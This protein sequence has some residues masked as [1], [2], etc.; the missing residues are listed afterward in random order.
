[1]RLFTRKQKAIY[2]FLSLVG[3]CIV[4]SSFSL[5]DIIIGL[6]IG[7]ARI[8]QLVE[9]DTLNVKVPG[10]TPGAGTNK[11]GSADVAE[12]ADA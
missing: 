1:M 7:F 4:V 11:K 10:S 6:I 12:L 8:A 9:Q 5:Y 2:I 3:L